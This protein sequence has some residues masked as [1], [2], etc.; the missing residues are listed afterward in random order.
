MRPRR[1]SAE[2][3]TA[4]RRALAVALLA[5]LAACSTL[6]SGQ[7]AASSSR[8]SAPTNEG[9][10]AIAPPSGFV[11]PQA[12]A[13]EPTPPEPEPA[14][15]APATPSRPRSETAGAT[16]SLLAQSRA[17]RAAGSYAQASA[18]IERALRIAPSDPRLWV[19]LGEIQLAS[20]DAAQ[21]ATLARKALTLAADDSVVI[22]DAQKLL[23]AAADNARRQP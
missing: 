4:A 19:E 1:S 22:A 17:A 3:G 15:T 6:E 7:R 16:Q 5:T 11:G 2:L 18:T 8:S 23:R 12:V 10:G 14:Q 20:G 9:S 21:A 13:P